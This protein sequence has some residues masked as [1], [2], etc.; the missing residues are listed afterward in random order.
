VTANAA[1][2]NLAARG[3]VAVEAAGAEVVDAAP[4]VAATVSLQS[5]KTGAL[6]KWLE[7]LRRSNPTLLKR[8]P[9]RQ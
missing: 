3:S 8:T 2:S 7:H 4:I 9:V 5:V 1:K 6:L